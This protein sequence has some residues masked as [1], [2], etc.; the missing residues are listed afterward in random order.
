MHGFRRTPSSARL[1]VHAFRH[2]AAGALLPASA[3]GARLPAHGCRRTASGARCRRTTSGAR[4][5]VHGFR[6][7]ASG[8]RLPAHGTRDSE[9]QTTASAPCARRSESAAPLSRARLPARG[10]VGRWRTRPGEGGGVRGG[11]LGPPPPREG[12]HCQVNHLTCAPGSQ[13]GTH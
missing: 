9:R 4:L 3:S 13:L 10:S 1:P 11:G 7:T 12:R 8:A 5:P 6:R 2:T